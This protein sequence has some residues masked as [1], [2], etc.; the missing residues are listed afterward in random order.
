MGRPFAGGPPPTLLD[1]TGWFNTHPP[2]SIAPEPEL[3]RPKS[4]SHKNKNIYMVF[5]LADVLLL[6]RE[7]TVLTYSF[8]LNIRIIDS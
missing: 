2:D 3:S 1:T 7:A 5:V 4:T 6:I 8:G